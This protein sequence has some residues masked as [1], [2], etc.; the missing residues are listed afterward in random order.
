M[1]LKQTQKSRSTSQ[2]LVQP[3]EHYVESTIKPC[4]PDHNP[5]TSSRRL[6]GWSSRARKQSRS[7]SVPDRDQCT[8][9][10]ANTGGNAAGFTAAHHSRKGFIR[11]NVFPH[12]QTPHDSSGL[13]VHNL[14]L[15]P[16]QL[17]NHSPPRTSS[18]SDEWALRPKS[19]SHQ[20]SAFH[21]GA[22]DP[23]QA[24]RWPA[25]NRASYY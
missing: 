16:V 20:E 10:S 11:F 2:G 9:E 22:E 3:V 14:S 19:S 13:V 21:P 8:A 23:V 15:G 25:E 12:F 17:A 24:F 7:P 18:S 5:L 1:C 4:R 6:I